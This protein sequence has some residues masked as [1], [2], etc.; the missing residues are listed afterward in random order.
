[1]L[2]WDVNA[3]MGGNLLKKSNY[4]KGVIEPF[5]QRGVP[6][7]TPLCPPMYEMQN[8]DKK[9]TIWLGPIMAKVIDLR[10]CIEKEIRVSISVFPEHLV[11]I[12]FLTERIVTPSPTLPSPPV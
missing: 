12:C 5:L 10:L 8:P 11:R 9:L 2:P 6:P 4:F 3:P 1:M 7:L